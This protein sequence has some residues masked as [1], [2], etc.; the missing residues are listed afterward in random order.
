MRQEHIYIAI[1]FMNIHMGYSVKE[2]FI[3][4]VEKQ[5]TKQKRAFEHTDY[6]IRI[7]FVRGKQWSSLL[8]TDVY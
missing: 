1:E 2:M 7:G 5:T 6:K 3:L 4:Q 8:Q